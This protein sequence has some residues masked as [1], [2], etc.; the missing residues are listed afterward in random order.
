MRYSNVLICIF[1]EKKAIIFHVFVIWCLVLFVEICICVI[2][3][4]T[5]VRLCLIFWNNSTAE[6]VTLN[7]YISLQGRMGLKNRP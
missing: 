5:Y 7:V 4:N 6:T 2:L 3:F 1:V